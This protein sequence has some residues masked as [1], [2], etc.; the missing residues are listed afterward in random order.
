[1][2]GEPK[3]HILG[4]P[5]SAEGYQEA[6]KIVEATYGKHIKV[7]KALIK[8]LESLPNITSL[9]KIKEIHE[10]YNE[11]SRTVRTLATMKKLQSA[12]S[13]VYSIMDKLGPVRE[14]LA[15]KDDNWEEWGLEELVENLRKYTDRNPLP[16]ASVQTHEAKKPG[17]NQGNHLRG[18][19]MLLSGSNRRQPRQPPPPAACIY[20]NSHHHRSSEC[21]KILDLSSRRE[22]LKTNR[23]CYN[24]ARPGHAASQCRSR[25]CGR[26]NSRHHTSICDRTPTTLPPNPAAES[27]ASSDKFYGANDFQTTLHSTVLAKVNGVQTRIM[28]DSG[29]GSSYIS[30][31]LLTKLNIK[32]YQTERRVIEQMYGTVDKQVEIYKVRVESNVIEDFVMELECIK[33][34]FKC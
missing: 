30:A 32:P 27:V 19:K 1:M 28:L 29:V 2:E 17:A 22:F 23:L 3:S 15:Q 26:C 18:D 24:C 9:A 21:T 7:H 14:A 16:E 6:K 34:T 25:G 5:H 31:N 11:L 12:Q 13:Y 4:L 10:F 8:D 33:C 20:C